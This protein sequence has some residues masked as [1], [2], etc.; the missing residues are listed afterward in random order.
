M[1][2]KDKLITHKKP[3]IIKS[4]LAHLVVEFFMYKHKRILHLI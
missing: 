2:S 1:P 4:T 3:V